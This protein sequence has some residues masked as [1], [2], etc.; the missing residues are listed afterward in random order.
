MPIG[1]LSVKY[2]SYYNI[3]NETNLFITGLYISEKYRSNKGFGYLG[4][5]ILHL[6]N[7]YNI[8]IEF[9]SNNPYLL[10]VLRSF[11]PK[12]ISKIYKIVLKEP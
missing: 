3:F 6:A 1:F 12:V 11:K 8:D 5:Q 7:L 2:T 10:K 4:T 9:A